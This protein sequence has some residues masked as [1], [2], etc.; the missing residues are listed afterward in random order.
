MED[1]FVDIALAAAQEVLGSP[2]SVR[3]GA[4]L[5]HE[6]TV[7]N[8]LQLAVGPR[9]PRRGQSAFQTDLAVF[10]TVDE[11]VQLP[12]VVLEFKSSLTTHDVLTYSTK[13]RKHKQVYPYLRYGIVVSGCDSLPG[14]FFRHNEALDFGVA[15]AAYGKARLHQ[16]FERLLKAEV[17]ASRDLEKMSCAGLRAAVVRFGV[18]VDTDAGRVV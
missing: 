3:R 15:A 8:R 17:A 18:K 11:G 9:D 10:E 5:L 12:R 2:L 16:L 1:E 13:A 14:R 6:V 7:D 4:A